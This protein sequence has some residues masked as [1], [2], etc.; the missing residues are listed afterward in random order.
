MCKKVSKG[1]QFPT[2][3][4][5]FKPWQKG[6]GHHQ[7]R[8]RNP[9]YLGEVATPPDNHPGVRS[10]TTRSAALFAIILCLSLD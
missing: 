8:R 4:N 1:K 2:S 3:E 10:Y 9:E 5:K 7:N 6:I